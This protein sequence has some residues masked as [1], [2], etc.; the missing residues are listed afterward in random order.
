MLLNHIY[1]LLSQ[2]K[3]IKGKKKINLFSLNDISEKSKKYKFKNNII[4]IANPP[5]NGVGFLCSF[6][7]L[8][9]SSN[10]FK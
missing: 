9:G 4:Q 7:T 10:K 2:L 6:L 1:H 8:S 5:I 3:P